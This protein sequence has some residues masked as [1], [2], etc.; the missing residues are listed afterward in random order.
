VHLRG[1]SPTLIRRGD[2][3]RPLLRIIE[4]HVNGSVPLVLT[5][6]IGPSA[7][8]ITASRPDRPGKVVARERVAVQEP[9]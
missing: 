9:A 1:E 8:R 5:L 4:A 6:E 3:L 2:V 7:V